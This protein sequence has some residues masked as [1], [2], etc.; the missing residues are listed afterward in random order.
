[1]GIIFYELLFGNL[2]GRGNDDVLR[3]KD[4]SKNGILFPSNI[5]ISC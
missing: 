2:P 1:M 3:I 5:R 4:I